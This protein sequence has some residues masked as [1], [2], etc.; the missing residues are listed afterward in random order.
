MENIK[1]RNVLNK[2][3]SPLILSEWMEYEGLLYYYVKEK[4]DFYKGYS[5]N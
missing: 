5:K 2:L 4:L 1:I 3:Y